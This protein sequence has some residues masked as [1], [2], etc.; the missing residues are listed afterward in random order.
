MDGFTV[1]R[2]EL[3]CFVYQVLISLV[4][5][6]AD[7]M[8]QNGLIVIML[9]KL[10]LFQNEYIIQLSL[11]KKTL[12]TSCSKESGHFYISVNTM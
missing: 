3:K 6:N 1:T 5:Y 8:A 10:H 11:T 7:F 2:S 4:S 9:H 12:G